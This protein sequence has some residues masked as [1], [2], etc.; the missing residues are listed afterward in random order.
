VINLIRS[1]ALKIR[2]TQVWLWMLL[3]AVGLTALATIAPVL[4]ADKGQQVDYYRIFTATQ[5]AQLAMLVLGVLG[6]TTEFRHKTITPTL[7]AAPDRTRLLLAKTL[8]YAVVAAIYG[9]VCTV[10]NIVVASI[11]LSAKGIDVSFGD[12]A[13]AGIVKVLINGVLIAVLGLGVG[14]LVRNQA[15]A[16]VISL[17]YFFVIDTLI[18]VIPYVQA[19]YPYTPG[20]ASDALTSNATDNGVPDGVHLLSPA[21]GGILFAAWA[22]GFVA[23]GGAVT[24][25]RDIS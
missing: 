17:V 7:L 10:V 3:L 9:V 21:L 23:L 6:L 1:E 14:T 15:A 13:G 20:G 25:R 4:D 22:L 18:E 16:M 2:G 12:G 11:W 24:L 5:L 8:T 19:A